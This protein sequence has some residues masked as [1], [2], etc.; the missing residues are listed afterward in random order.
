MFYEKIDHILAEVIDKTVSREIE[1]LKG[2]MLGD[3][4]ENEK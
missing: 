2:T 1:T 3:A 4:V